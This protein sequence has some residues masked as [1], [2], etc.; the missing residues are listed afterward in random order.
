[1]FFGDLPSG[2]A[3]L[4]SASGCRAGA[5]PYLC[6]VSQQFS[7]RE[8]LPQGRDQAILFCRVPLGGPQTSCAHGSLPYPGRRLPAGCGAEGRT[9]GPPLGRARDSSGGGRSRNT[10][11]ALCPRES[12]DPVSSL[13]VLRT[14]DNREASPTCPG[15]SSCSQPG[16]AVCRWGCAPRPCLHRTPQRGRGWRAAPT[17][18]LLP[19]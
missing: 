12:S 13:L 9:P 10:S 6:R 3:R 1:M 4:C 7:A 11:V 8:R 19:H 18:C 14:Q 16:E 17:P 2:K 15:R 5:V